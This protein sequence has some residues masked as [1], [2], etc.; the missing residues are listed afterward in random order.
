MPKYMTMAPTLV[1]E[2]F[3][4]EG[5]VFEELVARELVLHELG[6]DALVV[7]GADRVPHARDQRSPVTLGAEEPAARLQRHHPLTVVLARE[8]SVDAVLPV[9]AARRRVQLAKRMTG[10]VKVREEQPSRVQEVAPGAVPLGG[11]LEAL[12]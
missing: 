5:W 6:D 2:P 12:H 10:L 3:R 4:R 1:R 8:Q 9:V 7:V 11:F